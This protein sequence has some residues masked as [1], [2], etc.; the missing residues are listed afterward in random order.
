APPGW[1]VTGA[2]LIGGV[3]RLELLGPDAGVA[4]IALEVGDDRVRAFGAVGRDL[5][6]EV[7]LEAAS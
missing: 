3:G 4:P 5:V 7:A 2:R 1:R 6:V